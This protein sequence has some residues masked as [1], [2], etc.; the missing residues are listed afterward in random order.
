DGSIEGP[1]GKGGL[2]YG[3]AIARATAIAAG[4][5]GIVVAGSAPGARGSDSALALFYAAPLVYDLGSPKLIHVTPHGAIRTV[6]HGTQP[7]WSPRGL[8]TVTDDDGAQAI[9]VNGGMVA[10]SPLP[11][12]VLVSG[13][14]SWSPD[15]GLLPPP[16]RDPHR[17][18]SIG[19]EP[20]PG[21]APPPPP[22]P[23]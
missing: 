18:L 17:P 16:P 15:G 4:E 13:T 22:T 9:A 19:R 2:D 20:A 3:S 12:G 23:P 6:A 5:R 8:A 1:F 21:G 7:A 10:R 11:G 14:P